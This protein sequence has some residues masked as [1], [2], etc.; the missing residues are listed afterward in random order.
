MEDI[1][2]ITAIAVICCVCV[3]LTKQFRPE[4]SVFIQ[5][6]GLVVVIATG[7]SIIAKV[8]DFCQGIFS[9]SF[10]NSGYI[11]LLLKILGIAVVSKTGSDICRDSGNSALAFAVDFAAKATILFLILPMLESLAEITTG[12]LKG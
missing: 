9:E 7:M 1:L 3:L 6:A 10:L 12:L 11:V 4:L 2:K 8:I 5:L